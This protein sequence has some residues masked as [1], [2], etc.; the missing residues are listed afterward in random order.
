MEKFSIL[1]M[2]GDFTRKRKANTKSPFEV[3]YDDVVDPATSQ[4]S[5]ETSGTFPLLE[6]KGFPL[7]FLE[8]MTAGKHI[9]ST[10]GHYFCLPVIFGTLL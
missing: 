10:Y 3:L 7:A 5:K 4:S 6:K 8:L 2:D 1:I 9:L